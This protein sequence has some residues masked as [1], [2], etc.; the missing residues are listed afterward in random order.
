MVRVLPHKTTIVPQM[1]TGLIDVED[2]KVPLFE[3]DKLKSPIA[4]EFQLGIWLGF[5][6]EFEVG[7][8][9]PNA[10]SAVPKTK[11][12]L[13]N[14]YSELLKDLLR[15]SGEVEVSPAPQDFGV[16]Y[17]INQL[18]G[19]FDFATPLQ[20]PFGVNHKETSVFYV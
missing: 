3:I 7:P 6:N 19:D 17:V 2:F 4:L 10:V 11:S 15:T 12:L 5:P 14:S 13:R 1:S 16:S 18:S 9:I 20:D 8:G